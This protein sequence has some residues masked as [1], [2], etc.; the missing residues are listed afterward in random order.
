ML[1]LI[2]LRHAK[3][4]YPDGVKDHDRP[5]AAR[6]FE[7]APRMGAYL[8]GEHLIPDLVVVSTARRTQETFALIAKAYGEV[9]NQRSEKRIYEAEPE[10][11]LE[12]IRETPDIVRTLMLVG[13]N[14]GS[15]ELAAL[16]TG[17]GDRFAFA[18]MTQAYPTCA[19][20]VLDFDVPHWADV[21]ARGGR[22]E[23]FVTPASIGDGPDE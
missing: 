1:R 10:N 2:L 11:L 7:A 21:A 22:L 23:R 16:L 13:H 12:V 17:Y 20:A 18:R 9:L 5:L 4:G 8:A 19:V 6:G 14:P 15:Q 3:S